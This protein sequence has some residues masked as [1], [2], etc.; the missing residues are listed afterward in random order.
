MKRYFLAAIF[1]VSG[2][3][4]HALANE[5]CPKTLNFDK[6]Y[7]AS[8]TTV[9][10]C[11]EFQNQVLLIV[12]TASYCGF[13]PQYEGLE[14]LYEKYRKQGF[15]VLGFPSN[16]FFQEPKSEEVVQDFCRL[17][18]DVKFP[19]FEKTRVAKRHAEPL[20]QALADAAGEYPKWNFYKYLLSR[21]GKVV[22]SYGSRVKPNS[23]ELTRVIESLL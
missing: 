1:L 4:N 20:Y 6:R 14:R 11:E 17:T 16:D 7:L 9:K 3:S 15:T 22:A 10:L 19:M 18:Y 8:E 13:T 12:N 21:D 2:L 5:S 23:P